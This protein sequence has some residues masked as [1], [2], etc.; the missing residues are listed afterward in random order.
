MRRKESTPQ[1]ELNDT[2][3]EE[4]AEEIA[5]EMDAEESEE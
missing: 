3:Y 1:V 4:I 5:E 2:D